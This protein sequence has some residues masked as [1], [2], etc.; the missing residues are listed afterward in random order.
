MRTMTALAGVCAVLLTGCGGGG[1][2]S[3]PSA[4][5][6]AS[7]PVPTRAEVTLT[8][9]PPTLVARP[10]NDRTYPWLGEGALV[11]R[12]TAGLGGHV[13]YVNDGFGNSFGFENPSA[14]NH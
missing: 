3:A 8:V 6:P 11:L 12:E 4:P 2:A 10:N 13:H 14:R 1:S 5:V 7:T 9:S